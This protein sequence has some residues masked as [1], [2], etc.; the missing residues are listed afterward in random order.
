MLFRSGFACLLPLLSDWKAQ[1]GYLSRVITNISLWSYSLY[2]V[3]VPLL[4]F[5]NIVVAKYV[6]IYELK[7]SVAVVVAWV[8]TSVLLAKVLY[9]YWEKP[10]T[11]LR[12]K[13]G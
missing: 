3:H 2:L 8:I 4:E 12:D 6:D 9:V 11:A 1:E 13:L 10:T 7:I 5:V